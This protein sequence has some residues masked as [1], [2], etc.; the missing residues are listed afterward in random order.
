MCQSSAA[1]PLARCLSV[2][3]AISSLLD[4]ARLCY[5]IRVRENVNAVPS[6]QGAT[7]S[8]DW[9]R[10]AAH[11]CRPCCPVRRQC[12]LVNDLNRKKKLP[13][14]RFKATSGASNVDAI[15]GPASRSQESDSSAFS[16]RAWPGYGWK[17]LSA[18]RQQSGPKKTRPCKGWARKEMRPSFAALC[19]RKAHGKAQGTRRRRWHLVVA[20]GA[21]VPGAMALKL[22]SKPL[23]RSEGL[24]LLPP[25]L[26]P[27][28]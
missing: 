11:S 2:P 22:G 16:M 5:A 24:P 20:S 8:A 26:L 27:W 15:F 21:T 19:L 10:S 25:L 7:T 1:A 13:P 28:P 23:V 6:P 17:Q 9:K 12:H 3:F 18:P 14:G 4:P